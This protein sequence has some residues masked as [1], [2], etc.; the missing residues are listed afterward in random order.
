MNQSNRKIIRKKI[1]SLAPKM[2]PL[3]PNLPSH[4]QGR[5]AIAHMYDVLKSVFGV[6]LEQVS[7]HRLND[8]LAILDYCMANAKIK[9]V[10]TPLR[11]IY[12]PEP[13]PQPRATL[14][15]FFE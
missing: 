6:P 13:E 1:E 3:L 2:Q 9:S 12:D 4:P 14:D 8:A 10:A 5:I 11:L 7:D 15:R